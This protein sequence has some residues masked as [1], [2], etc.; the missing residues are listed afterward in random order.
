MH[1]VTGG[2]FHGKH[3]WVREHYKLQRR[4]DYVVHNGFAGAKVLPSSIEEGELVI[5]TGLHLYIRMLLG[6]EEPRTVLKHWLQDAISWEKGGKT[7]VL[8]G[9][10]IGKGIVPVKREDREWRDLVGLCYQDIVRLAERV[11]LIWYGLNQQI[12]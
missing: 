6:H 11:D 9:N 5:V 8:I 4:S 10:E 12:K 1:F 3:Q 7:V 2:A